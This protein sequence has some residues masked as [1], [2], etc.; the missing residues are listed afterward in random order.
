MDLL[1]FV[2]QKTEFV[3]ETSSEWKIDSLEI[4]SLDSI[5]IFR[6]INL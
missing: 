1:V 2:W 4:N 6:L 3:I 5:F